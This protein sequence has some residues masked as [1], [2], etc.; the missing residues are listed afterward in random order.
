MVGTIGGT[1]KG[2]VAGALAGGV[3]L[4][5]L[6]MAI[7]AL[8]PGVEDLGEVFSE[9]QDA[10][11]DN[12][13]SHI[14]QIDKYK[15]TLV[16]DDK[17]AIRELDKARLTFVDAMEAAKDLK[18]ED[19]MTFDTYTQALEATDD[20]VADLSKFKGL[21]LEL[22]TPKE[23]LN[24]ML[25]KV[26]AGDIV[27]HDELKEAVLADFDKSIHEVDTFIDSVEK[28]ADKATIKELKDVKEG[29]IEAKEAAE[30]LSAKDLS[31]RQYA[32][33]LTE[34]TKDHI[35]A[36]PHLEGLED[37]NKLRDAAEKFNDLKADLEEHGA[38]D[39][40]YEKI[41]EAIADKNDA[42]WKATKETA[43]LGA[44]TM[45][46]AGGT[47]GGVGGALGIGKWTN[48]IASERARGQAGE[49][50]LGA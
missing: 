3:G 43:A 11:V 40:I 4:G 41:T 24:E 49:L 14:D 9:A 23:M 16:A 34:V 1:I 12:L 7:H 20:R 38:G 21:E 18:V 31:T 22:D 17:D 50:N 46:A 37:T 33:K 36:A 39:K 35:I 45:G 29:L 15:E 42:D 32:A 25:E 6:M 13:K 8:A 10:V 47:A 44:G 19:H 26:G 30:D 2:G 27:E 5:G 28:T 48:K